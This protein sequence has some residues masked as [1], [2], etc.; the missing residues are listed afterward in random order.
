[1]QTMTYNYKLLRSIVEWMNRADKH[2]GNYETY[3]EI[4]EAGYMSFNEVLQSIDHILTIWRNIEINNGN[5]E[6]V[7]AIIREKTKLLLLYT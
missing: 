2:G 1:M 6:K 4:I 3:L 7:K 5:A